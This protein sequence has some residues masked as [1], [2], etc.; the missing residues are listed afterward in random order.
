MILGAIIC[1]FKGHVFGKGVL[2]PTGVK[3]KTCKRCRFEQLVRQ[4]KAKV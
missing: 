1:R 4:R 3:F 2:F